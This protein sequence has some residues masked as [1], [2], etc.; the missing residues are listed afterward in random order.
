LQAPLNAAVAA[1]F[2]CVPPTSLVGAPP[3]TTLNTRRAAAHQLM[4]AQGSS[5]IYCW[6]HSGFVY[7]I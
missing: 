4:S 7:N 1:D 3:P 2:I 6:R 5:D